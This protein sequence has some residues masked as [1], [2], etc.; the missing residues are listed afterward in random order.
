VK[1]DLPPLVEQ[2][3]TGQQT[4]GQQGQAVQMLIR[5]KESSFPEG[6]CRL[7]TRLVRQGET[8]PLSTWTLNKVIIQPKREED[9]EAKD[10]CLLTCL[11][12][13]ICS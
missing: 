6:D 9:L 3:R 4:R 10:A 8:C 13:V 7:S 11:F 1:K 5:V 2:S 12:K